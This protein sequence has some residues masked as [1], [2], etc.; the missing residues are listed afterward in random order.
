MNEIFSKVIKSDNVFFKYAKGMRDI[1]G[2]EFHTYHEIFLFL[3]GEAEFI[4]ESK[5]FILQKN[6][7]VIIPKE[8]YHQ[9][10]VFCDESEYIRCVFNF[11]DI[12]EIEE[13]I[14]QKINNICLIE[15]DKNILNVFQKAVELFQCKLSIETKNQIIKSILN[16]LLFEIYKNETENNL[17]ETANDFKEITNKAIKYI[18][19]KISENISVTDIANDLN[20][21]ASYLRHTFK[22][23]M[24]ISI[25][26]Y[27]LEKKLIIANQKID[28]GEMATKAALDCG[29]NDYSGFY[30][31]FKK[32]FG[33]PPSKV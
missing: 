3:D 25:Y 12:H 26:K 10:N 8:K 18:N 31:Q 1:F 30:R 4:S 22:K 16:L 9:F 24:N 33:K 19:L 28:S 11:S 5:K 21:S 27:I 20:V 13:I 23:D 17:L 29:F 6:T 2:K 14:S 7:L 15:V 32:M